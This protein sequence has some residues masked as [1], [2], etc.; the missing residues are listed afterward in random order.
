MQ[1]ILNRIRINIAEMML[2]SGDFNVSETAERCGFHDISYFSN[3]F[4][5]MRGY[6][7]SSVRKK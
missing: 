4:K 6:S 7:P 2:S 3:L 5:T 1:G